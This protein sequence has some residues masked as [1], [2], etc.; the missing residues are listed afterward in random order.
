MT[1]I[2]KYKLN[3]ISYLS[4]KDK[5]WGWISPVQPANVSNTQVYGSKRYQM[6]SNVWCWWAETGKNI[7][8]KHHLYNRWELDSLT[9]RKTNNQYLPIT[10]AELLRMWPDFHAALDNKMV[11]EMLAHG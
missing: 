4:S 11:F 8:V 9:K 7:S 5:L 6:I 3:H 10:E 2:E 1:Q